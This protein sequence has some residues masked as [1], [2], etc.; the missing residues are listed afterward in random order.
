MLIYLME[1]EEQERKNHKN[2]AGIASDKADGLVEPEE[3]SEEE[4]AKDAE[5][6][7]VIDKQNFDKAIK[8]PLQEDLNERDILEEMKC[9]DAEAKRAGIDKRLSVEFTRDLRS[10][11]GEGSLQFRISQE[12]PILNRRVNG[13]VHKCEAVLKEISDESVAHSLYN[14]HFEARPIRMLTDGRTFAKKKK[15]GELPRW[16]GGVVIDRSTSMRGVREQEAAYAAYTLYETM[17]K[18]E[19]PVFVIGHQT[20]ISP[21]AQVTITSIADEHS[22]R[23][24]GDRILTYK[25]PGGC[26]RDGYAIRYAANKLAK[27]DADVKLLI[28]ASDGLP[29]DYSDE[30]EGASDCREAIKLAKA[31]GLIPIVVGI[32]SQAPQIKNL[33][34]EGVK[35]KDQPL[36][37]DCSQPEL[38]TKS[39]VKLLTKYICQE[40]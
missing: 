3:K 17:T 37:L 13:L 23:D 24:E 19:F 20:G 38:I 10:R 21:T 31:L 6:D 29:S 16:A 39:F 27:I 22:I 8:Q 12:K 33:Y 35:K 7:A 11:E 14:G 18:L 2:C 26:N 32:G 4:Q 28:I 36:F 1:A 15:P 9:L 5:A 34:I 40:D 25:G 30:F